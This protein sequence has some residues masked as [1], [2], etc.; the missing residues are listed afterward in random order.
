MSE[1]LVVIDLDGLR[2]GDEPAPNPSAVGTT[3]VEIQRLAS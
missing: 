3:R 2:A 1:Y